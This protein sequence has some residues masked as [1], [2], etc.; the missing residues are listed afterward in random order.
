VIFFVNF[1]LFVDIKCAGWAHVSKDFN[2]VILLPEQKDLSQLN[3]LFR[4]YFCWLDLE[5]KNCYNRYFSC[6]STSVYGS[7]I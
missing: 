5:I 7:C 4:A 3:S 1:F 6:T 2:A